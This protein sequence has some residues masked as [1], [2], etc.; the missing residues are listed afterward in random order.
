MISLLTLTVTR[1][2]R[3]VDQRRAFMLNP[4]GLTK[5]VLEDKRNGQLNDSVKPNQGKGT[6]PY[7][8]YN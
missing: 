3:K 1:E 8:I 2:G 4:F 5:K 6:C 7:E